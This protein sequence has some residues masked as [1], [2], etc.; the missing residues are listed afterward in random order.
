[1]KHSV[2]S[3]WFSFSTHKNYKVSLCFNTFSEIII[4]LQIILHSIQR[5]G[6]I[7]IWY[8]RSV[9]CSELIRKF[10]ILHSSKQSPPVLHSQSWCILCVF[11]SRKSSVGCYPAENIRP[12]HHRATF[13]SH[14]ISRQNRKS[15]RRYKSKQRRLVKGCHSGLELYVVTQ[16]SSLCC[17]RCEVTVG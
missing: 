10:S 11:S 7:Q 14:A 16:V 9:M 6:L 12:C 5:G 4:I 3:S 1:M 15:F 2:T 17:D 13:T 8:V